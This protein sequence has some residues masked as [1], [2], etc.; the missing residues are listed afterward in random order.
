M[1]LIFFIWLLFEF[2]ATKTLS[3]AT[4]TFFSELA[5]LRP[6]LLSVYEASERLYRK[7]GC[8]SVFYIIDNSSDDDYFGKL[9]VLCFELEDTE[10]FLLHIIKAKDNL[11]YSGGNNLILDR[12]GSDYHLVVNP[13]V[14]LDSDA[15]LLSYEYMGESQEV[16]MLSPRIVNSHDA[17][18]VVKN[19]PDCLTL[20]LRFIDGPALNR[21]FA[22]RL[23]HYKCS[24]LGNA[25]PAR[26]SIV[27]GCFLFLKTSVF[28]ELNGFD[29]QFFM[30]FEDYDLSLRAGKLGKIAY[31]PNVKITHLGGY[32]GK[33]GFRHIIYF[34]V[35]AIKFFNRYRWRIW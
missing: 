6:L 17:Q 29:N 5:V 24:D 14:T 15:L 10:S 33:K 12:L 9:K 26:V 32:V 21:F 20:A 35:S 23:D 3:I 8:K 30:Y 31:V 19:Y 7:H 34:V 2:M 22:K 4:V 1:A 16:I 25:A 18:H 13:D 28:K 27:G 11:G